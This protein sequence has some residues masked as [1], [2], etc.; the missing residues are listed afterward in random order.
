MQT[1]KAVCVKELTT[2]GNINSVPERMTFVRIGV[3]L[4]GCNISQSFKIHHK[5]ED[6]HL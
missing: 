2:S 4:Q 6:Y 3:N 5:Q 1:Y